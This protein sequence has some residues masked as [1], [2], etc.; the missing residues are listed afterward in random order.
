V[1]NLA[2]DR[3]EQPPEDASDDFR[4]GWVACQDV[5]LRILRGEA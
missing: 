3:R 4:A 2:L 5:M 1:W